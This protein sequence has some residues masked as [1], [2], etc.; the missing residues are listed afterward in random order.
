MNTIDPA[1][2]KSWRD[3]RTTMQR[4]KTPPRVLAAYNKIARLL[5]SCSETATFET[6]TGRVIPIRKVGGTTVSIKKSVLK[7]QPC[8]LISLSGP[9]DDHKK[10]AHSGSNNAEILKI[11]TPN[12]THPRN[13]QWRWILVNL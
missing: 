1:A 6:N 7:V 9:K 12:S 4:P 3:N 5:E 8:Q 13:R 10:L 11:A 2:P